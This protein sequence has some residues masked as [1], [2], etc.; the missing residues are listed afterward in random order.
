MPL[1]SPSKPAQSVPQQSLPVKKTAEPVS[2]KSPP[3][4][5]VKKTAEITNS[6][7]TKAV[8]GAAVAKKEAP[9]EAE[10]GNTPVDML[11]KLQADFKILEE[12]LQRAR[13]DLKIEKPNDAKKRIASLL[14][15]SKKNHAKIVALEDE[16][17]QL[18]KMLV[19]DLHH[20][21]K[22]FSLCPSLGS[23]QLEGT[24][25]VSPVYGSMP[26][27]SESN[28]IITKLQNDLIKARQNNATLYVAL[29]EQK[30]IVCPDGVAMP[31]RN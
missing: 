26:S 31:S 29:K 18:K 12:E 25:A 17:R 10:Y 27:S 11:R 21:N 8:K 16:N 23:I 14:D 5:P 4:S 13:D 20:A 2:T 7:K 30:L 22:T 9:E 1:K 15:E 3:K 6:P 28:A 24:N 19:N